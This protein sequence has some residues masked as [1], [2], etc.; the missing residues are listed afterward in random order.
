MILFAGET[1][2][3]VLYVFAFNVLI[4][5]YFTVIFALTLLNR[6]FFETMK[7]TTDE[8]FLNVSYCS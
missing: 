1:D 6:K 4:L 2:C 5:W 8:F 7:S 3:W